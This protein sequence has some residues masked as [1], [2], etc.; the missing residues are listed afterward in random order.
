MWVCK[1]SFIVLYFVVGVEIS[2]FVFKSVHMF[3]VFAGN[4][5]NRCTSNPLDYKD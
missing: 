4:N 2:C 3:L 1:W 5:P